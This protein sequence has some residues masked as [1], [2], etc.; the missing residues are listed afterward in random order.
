MPTG[1]TIANRPERSPEGFIRIS[2]VAPSRHIS[3]PSQTSFDLPER[4]LPV[5]S[6]IRKRK[7]NTLQVLLLEPTSKGFLGCAQDS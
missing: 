4:I 7:V 1:G 3:R 6:F 2:W 5:D